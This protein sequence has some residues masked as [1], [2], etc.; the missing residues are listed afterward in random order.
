MPPPLQVLCTHI[1][2]VEHA[3]GSHSL[4]YSVSLLLSCRSPETAK[5][6]E[7]ILAAPTVPEQK[8]MHNKLFSSIEWAMN[9]VLEL[10][11]LYVDSAKNTVLL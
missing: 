7:I 8:E 2:R 6:L 1:L 4:S 3:Y 10:F 11:S 9:I 5:P